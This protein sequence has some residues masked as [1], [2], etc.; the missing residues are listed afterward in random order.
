MIPDEQLLQYAKDVQA[1]RCTWFD[2]NA[3]IARRYECENCGMPCE[4]DAELCDRC[5]LVERWGDEAA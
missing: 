3:D 2:A 4:L 5:L 1:G